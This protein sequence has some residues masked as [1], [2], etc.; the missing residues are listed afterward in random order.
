M[1]NRINL[2]FFLTRTFVL[3]IVMLFLFACMSVMLLLRVR[4]L[5]GRQDSVQTNSVVSLAADIVNE[6]INTRIQ[7]LSSVART[8]ANEST[9]DP[10]KVLDGLK[11]YIAFY[12]A[13]KDEMDYKRISIADADGTVINPDGKGYNVYVYDSFQRALR[14]FSSTSSVMLD[15]AAKDRIQG[16]EFIAICV[17]IYMGAEVIGT[18]NAVMGLRDA[19]AFLKNINIQYNGAFLFLVD[20]ENSVISNSGLFSDPQMF[21]SSSTNVFNFMGGILSERE[22]DELAARMS[23]AADGSDVCNYSSKD[24]GRFISYVTLPNTNNWKLIAISSNNSIRGEQRKLLMTVA[25]AFTALTLLLITIILSVYFYAWRSSRLQRISNAMLD[26]SGLHLLTLHPSGRAE[27]FDGGFAELLGLPA[28]TRDFN[29]GDITIAGQK[30]FPHAPFKGGESLRLCCAVSGGHCVYLL[31]QLVEA[32][33]KGIGQAL[34]LD[35]TK[36]EKMQQRI[37]DLAYVNKLTG[38]PNSEVFSQKI[39]AVMAEH[40]PEDHQAVCCFVEINNANRILEIFGS[41][42]YNKTI[43][44]AASRLKT[45]VKDF[46]AELYSLKYDNFVVY[47]DYKDTEELA[48]LREAIKAAF[49]APFRVGSSTFDV[50]C[51][52]GVITYKEYTANHSVTPDDIF[53][54]GEIATRLAKENNGVCHLDEKRYRSILRRLDIETA[55]S[56]SLKNCEMELYYQPIYDAM[57][58]RITSV[59]ALSRWHSA[60]HGDIPPGVFIPMAEKSGFINALGDWVADESIAFAK[61]LK[62]AG[63]GVSVEFNVSPVQLA[64]ADFIPK[65][66]AKVRD[67]GLPPHSL[68]IEI[69]ES[70]CLENAV[71]LREMLCPVKEAGIAIY[72]DDFGTGYS[73]ISYLKDLSADY[74]KVDKS[75]VDDIE[76]SAIQR[77]IVRAIIAVARATGQKVIVEGVESEDELAVLLSIGCTKIQGYLIAKPMDGES[78]LRFLKNFSGGEARKDV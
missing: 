57:E 39:R 65:L 25:A 77:E 72:I 22:S 43:A 26:S 41:P 12:Q 42:V 46:K 78:L 5:Y 11:D 13:S 70:N 67:S 21:L 37:R 23:S 32:D 55:L 27:G 48:E 45:A 40:P 9:R 53:R 18:L 6:R 61:R 44:E 76:N 56:L 34:A 62:N 1:K 66:L 15:P 49:F 51:N 58:D 24:T 73:T 29:F 60:S 4:E 14:G 54:Y 2:H 30:I 36:D 47:H 71:E 17:P 35:I 3:L 38:L 10:R 52:I 28:K 19:A 33:P 69:T 75:F 68:G 59:E 7:M 16:T 63:C 50:S 74:I 8:R 31:I 64:Q 20:G